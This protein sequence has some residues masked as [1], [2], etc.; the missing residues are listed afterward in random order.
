MTPR[1]LLE[2]LDAL[3]Y[4]LR[5]SFCYTN[6]ANAPHRWAASSKSIFLKG[7]NQSFAHVDADRSNLPA[8]Q[9]IRFESLV[10][11]RGRVWEI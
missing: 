4:T 7:T 8:L 11:N 9:A 1:A 3:G 2:E 6:S 10:F 5:H